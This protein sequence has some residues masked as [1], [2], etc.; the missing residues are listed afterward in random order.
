METSKI[1]EIQSYM[2]TIEVVEWDSLQEYHRV[3][4]IKSDDPVLN[5]QSKHDPLERIYLEQ[6]IKFDDG[7][8]IVGKQY[9]LH[10]VPYV[11]LPVLHEVVEV[12]EPKLE[13]SV[14][15]DEVA[16][17]FRSYLLNDQPVSAAELIQAASNIDEYFADAAIKS[18]SRAAAILRE[19]GGFTVT[20]NAR[21]ES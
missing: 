5:I 19:R 8:E 3:R 1:L 14:D 11:W 20:D 21:G 2:T 18:T 10:M 9:L 16:T 7:E 13:A 17:L 15:T 4:I 6:R 12:T